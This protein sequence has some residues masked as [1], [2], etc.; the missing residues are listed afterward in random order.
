MIGGRVP[1]WNPQSF[2]A[3]PFEQWHDG[4]SRKL[5]NSS[6]SSSPIIT[7]SPTPLQVLLIVTKLQS[8]P[9]YPSLHSQEP[10]TQDPCNVEFEHR[11]GHPHGP[12]Y[13]TPCC[14]GVK[15]FK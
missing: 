9:P 1:T 6:S 14:S 11:L 13:C 5:S 4:N 12:G 15:V 7:T 10:D 3:I 8:S 2:P